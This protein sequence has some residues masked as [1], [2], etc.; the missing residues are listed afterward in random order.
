[1][2]NERSLFQPGRNFEGR[3]IG[4]YLIQGRLG[5]GGAAT[6]FQ[7]Y[8][9]VD[10]RS[11]ALKVLLPTADP[12]TIRCWGVWMMSPQQ[13]ALMQRHHCQQYLG[14]KPATGVCANQQILNQALS[15][16]L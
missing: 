12:N 16:I 6:V 10:G 8:D 11:V 9:Q 15:N 3:Q 14:S 1:M 13:M 5:S 4:R 2:G 7:A